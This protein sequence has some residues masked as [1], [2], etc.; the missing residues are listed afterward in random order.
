MNTTE[1]EIDPRPKAIVNRL[2]AECLNVGDLSAADQLVS[3]DF[4][5][6]SGKGPESFK[7]MISPLRQGFPDLHFTIQE[8][9]AEGSRVVVRWTSQGTHRGMFAGTAPTGRPVS[10]EGI[11]IYR[12]EDGK[13]VESWSQVDRLGVLQQIG[14]VPTFGRGGPAAQAAAQSST[15][16]RP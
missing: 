3:P 6:P 2:F 16:R 14:A 10:N 1:L 4:T 7:A 11:G 13:I 5:G 9:V 15:E 8:M 12:V